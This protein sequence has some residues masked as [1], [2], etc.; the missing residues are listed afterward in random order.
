[1]QGMGIRGGQTRLVHQSGRF[2]PRIFKGV[3]LVMPLP[4][5]IFFEQEV[6]YAGRPVIGRHTDHS[7]IEPEA[8]GLFLV[9]RQATVPG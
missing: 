3:V 2:F 8:A 4:L 9:K 5:G 6:P 1:M 7:G